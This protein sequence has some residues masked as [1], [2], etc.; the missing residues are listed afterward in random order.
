MGNAERFEQFLKILGP[1]PKAVQMTIRV[2][3]DESNL[4]EPRVMDYEF[5]KREQQIK[6]S[7]KIFK[8]EK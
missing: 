7:N 5:F 3:I 4:E 8:A 1:L 6:N 2:V